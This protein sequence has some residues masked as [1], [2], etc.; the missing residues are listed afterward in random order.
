MFA[1]LNNALEV[2]VEAVVGLLV[3]TSVKT[4]QMHRPSENAHRALRICSIIGFFKT[5]CQETF[6]E[7][8]FQ[9]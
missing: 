7:C 5:F 6:S 3:E 1:A 9:E 8:M 4:L 2:V